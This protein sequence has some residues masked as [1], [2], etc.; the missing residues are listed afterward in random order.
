MASD[1]FDIVS[2]PAR[3]GILDLLVEGPRSV[4]EIVERTGMS[5]PN[6]SRH[7]RILRES[8][9]VQASVDRQRRIYELRPEGL[10]ELIGWLGP[11]QRLWNHHLDRLEARLDEQG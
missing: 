7:L 4:G 9:L 8:G 1:V 10:A 11:Y 3:R 6:A 2:E 5:Q